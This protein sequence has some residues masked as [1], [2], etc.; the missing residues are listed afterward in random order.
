MLCTRCEHRAA[1]YEI[2]TG[3]RYECQDITTSVISC[4][5]YLPVRP[6]VLKKLKGDKRPIDAGWLF[7]AR[8]E[9]TRLDSSLRL[10]TRIENNG[11]IV[12]FWGE[13]HG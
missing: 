13:E 4:Y 11:E 3:P 7:A 8:L 12:K 2:A 10:I 5:M 1:F 6:V 9:G